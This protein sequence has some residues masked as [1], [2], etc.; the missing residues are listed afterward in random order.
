MKW[1]K[2]IFQKH[3]P[4][5]PDLQGAI[6]LRAAIWWV[7]ELARIYG[8]KAIITFKRSTKK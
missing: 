6:E 2:K 5:Q 3:E 7:E 1:V 8:Y 4:V